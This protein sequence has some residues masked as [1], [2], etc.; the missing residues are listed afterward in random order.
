MG[1]NDLADSSP[2]SEQQ[3]RGFTVFFYYF[4]LCI[5]AKLL[6]FSLEQKLVLESGPCSFRGLSA[7][8]QF[9]LYAGGRSL[10]SGCFNAMWVGTAN[11]SLIFFDSFDCSTTLPQI[12]DLKF[13]N[14]HLY[15]FVQ[16]WPLFCI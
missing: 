9:L 4:Y 12:H 16:N 8:A 10:E 5:S 1:S 3:T 14:H 11:Y 13:W 7:S 2:L 15:S 6:P